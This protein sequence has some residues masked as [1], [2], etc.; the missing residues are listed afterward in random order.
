MDES[1]KQWLN[2][3][4]RDYEQ[5]LKG[6]NGRL[7]KKVPL[8]MALCIGGMTA[9][10]FGVG[11]DWTYVLRVHLPI[12]AG[13]AAFVWLCFWLQTRSVSVKKVRAQYE[14]CLGALSPSDQAAF[15]MQTSQCGKVDFLNQASDKYP[16]RLMVGPDYWL[17][18]RG[19]CRVFRVADIQRLYARQETTRVGYNL[20][21]T[22][23]RQNLGVGVSL[24]A[25]FREGTGAGAQSRED[26]IY[27]ENSKQLEQAEDLIRRYCPKGAGLFENS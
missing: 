4:M 5:V 23:V 24:V 13:L 27:L 8:W 14:Q 12:G 11:Y 2:W 9:L 22:H 17:Y 6:F 10:G 15:A 19:G 3:E 16:A 26:K 25:E 18:F 20:G 21:D 7:M 1:L